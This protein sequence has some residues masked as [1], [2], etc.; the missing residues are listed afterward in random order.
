MSGKVFVDTNILIYA[1]NLDA[2]LKQQKAAQRLSIL[3]QTKLGRLSTQILQEFFVTITS[4][5]PKPLPRAAAR[6][7]IR[8][9]AQW[10]ESLISP[11]TILRATEIA[12]SSILSFWDS[13]VIAA[14]EQDGAEE[15]LSEDLNHG[16]M[17]AG[18]RV[19]NPFL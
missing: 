1:H 12:D 7:I 15:V 2:G 13:M 4:K 8:S 16:Q 19:V 14:A 18:V 11:S 5:I 3:W 9:Y 17:I 6:E 10:V